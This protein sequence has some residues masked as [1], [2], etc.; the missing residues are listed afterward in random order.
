MVIWAANFII[1]KSALHELPPIGFTTIRFILA[2]TVLLAVCRLVEGSVALPRREILPLAVLGAVGFGLYQPLWTVGLGQTS[3]SDSSLL[4]AFTPIWTLLIAAA[5][6]S[7]RLTPAR[8]LGTVVSFAGVGLVVLSAA[9]AGLGGHLFGDLITVVAS[10]LWASFMAFIAP[11][12]TRVSPLRATAWAVT[13]GTFVMAPL[14][15]WQLSTVDWGG[16]TV[17]SALALAYSGLVSI[18][19]G[20]IVQFRAVRAIGPARTTAFQ[21]LV[22]AMTVVLAALILGEQIRPEQ[23]VGGAVII[24]GIAIARRV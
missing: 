13:F 14:G 5:I 8:L 21:F 23:I 4:V 11:V 2:A 6:G 3:A 16:V 18:A 12:L 15:A 1:V 7:D 22:P 10:V 19:L 20:N 9:G 17:A 24:L